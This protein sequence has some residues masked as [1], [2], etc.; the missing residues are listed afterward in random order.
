MLLKEPQLAHR[1]GFALVVTLSLMILLTVI[2]VGLLT[3][4]NISLRASTQGQAMAVA[5]ANAKLAMMLA[6][7]ELQKNAGPDQCVTARGDILTTNTTNPHWTAVWK[8]GANT[9]DSGSPP[10]RTTS[11]GASDAT[12]TQKSTKAAWL[13]SGTTP[14]PLTFH[15]TTTGANPTAVALA[16]NLGADSKTVMAP[17]VPVQ[18]S[19]T[20]R[21]AYAYWVSDEGVKAKVNIKDPTLNSASHTV[22]PVTDL[23]KNQLHF[24]A[25]Q[26]MA[27]HKILPDTLATDFRQADKVEQVLTPQTLPLLPTAAPTGYVS[28]RYLAD[29]TTYSYGVLADVRNGGLRKD[30]TAAFEDTGATAAKNYAKLNPNSTANVYTTSVDGIPAIT[31]GNP[32]FT[33]LRWLNLYYYYNLYK[34]TL[35][36]VS[37]MGGLTTPALAVRPVGIGDPNPATNPRPYAVS[38]HALGWN[39]SNSPVFAALTPVCLGLRWDVALSTRNTGAGYVPRLHYYPQVVLYNPYTVAIKSS[40]FYLRRSLLA[41]FYGATYSTSDFVNLTIGGTT[42]SAAMCQGS[43]GWITLQTKISESSDFAP[44]EI[45]VYGLSPATAKDYPAVPGLYRNFTNSI[46]LASGSFNATAPGGLVSQDYNPEA[47]NVT[48]MLKVINYATYTPASGTGGDYVEIPPQPDGPVTVS[49]SKYVMGGVYNGRSYIQ[50]GLI[51]PNASSGDQRLMEVGQ[52]GSYDTG[53]GTLAGGKPFPAETPY[54]TTLSNLDIANGH[55]ILLWSI[56]LRIKGLKGETSGYSNCNA[57]LPTFMGNT[58]AFNAQNDK[59]FSGCWAELYVRDS[60]T[61]WQRYDFTDLFDMNLGESPAN[62]KIKTTSWGNRST[63]VEVP[64]NVVGSPASSVVLADVPIQ[65]LVSLGQFMHMRPFYSQ[66]VVNI[67]YASMGFGTMFTGGSYANPSVKLETTVYDSGSANS[68]QVASSYLF[69]DHSFLANQALFDSYYF[70]TVPP[71]SL[72]TAVASAPNAPDPLVPVRA[73]VYPANWVAFNAAN[74]AGG[75]LKDTSIPFLNSRMVPYSA[76][77]IA[78]AM[79]DLRD[80]DKAATNLLL[81]GAFNINSTSIDAWRTLLSSLAG[82]DLSLWDASTRAAV[83]FP[84]AKLLNPIPRFWTATGNATLNSAWCGVRALTDTEVTELATKIVAQVKLRGPFLSMADFLNRRLGAAASALTLSG[85]LQAAIDTTVPDINATAK[86]A[87]EPVSVPNVALPYSATPIAANMQDANLT[88][89]NTATGIP[90][91]LMQ[92]DLVQAFSPVMTARSDTFVI[93]TYG[94]SS[95]PVT[96]QVEA[97]AYAEAVV[98]RVPDYLDPSDPALSATQAGFAGPAGNATP[99]YK[100]DGVTTIVNTT[101]KTFGRRFKIISFRWLAPQEI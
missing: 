67:G 35:P 73:S 19:S 31:P 101:N 81:N 57:H 94:E 59:F 100:A 61:Q 49:L 24:A 95:N 15:G 48:D 2:A 34:A 42:Y 50:C 8:T 88:Q 60:S 14:D 28:N 1:K 58:E 63:G 20:G 38:M 22:D 30:L 33:G 86:A 21:G 65:P 85:A 10:Q 91:Y 23:A 47:G 25:P 62:P 75:S 17:L 78:P 83:T 32:M 77:G 12:D 56:Y 84:A 27:A 43:T 3:L 93:R 66:S 9:L 92:Q 39:Q 71:A 40:S 5:Q 79:A 44:G 89:W 46:A 36:T 96:N 6:L 29:V 72:P 80:M 26:A 55:P 16:N 18:S 51:W 54:T 37:N 74:P 97:R 64:A 82:N 70:S 4:S 69:C 68:Y 98:Q 76:N 41:L 53:S 11:L 52:P 7:G 99:V 90:G 87:G 45:R 13:V